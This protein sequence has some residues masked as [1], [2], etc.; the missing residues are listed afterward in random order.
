MPLIVIQVYKSMLFPWYLTSQCCH[1]CGYAK[2][3]HSISVLN[4]VEAILYLDSANFPVGLWVLGSYQEMYMQ[5]NWCSRS[6]VSAKAVRNQITMCGMMRWD[7]QPSNHTSAVVQA[8][9]LS[10]FGHSARMLD[11]TDIK[12]IST[13]YSPWRTGGDHQDT[14]VLRGRRLSSKAWNPIIS[15]RMKQ[16]T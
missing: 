11:K 7:G 15:P 4:W 5:N 6:V 1:S 8:Q 2:P 10:L 16:L 12:K 13:A 3:R 14:L 9:R